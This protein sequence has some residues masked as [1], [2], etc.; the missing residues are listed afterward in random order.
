MEG[1]QCYEGHFEIVC[2]CVCL[3]VHVCVCWSVGGSVGG[4]VSV[5]ECV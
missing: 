4:C 2:V 1:D 3:F 5:W